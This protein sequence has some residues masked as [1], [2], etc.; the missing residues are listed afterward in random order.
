MYLK[1][2]SWE[3]ECFLIYNTLYLSKFIFQVSFPSW[4]FHFSHSYFFQFN[5]YFTMARIHCIK[6]RFSAWTSQ[7]TINY[8]FFKCVQR[9][10]QIS[11]WNRTVLKVKYFTLPGS[12]GLFLSLLSLGFFEKYSNLGSF[13][14]FICTTFLK[15]RTFILF[16]HCSFSWSNCQKSITIPKYW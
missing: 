11:V 13:L 9:Q 16:L 15:K 8:L 7:L 2:I 3:S 1:L 12:W 14:V 4:Q 10:K 5:R 6:T